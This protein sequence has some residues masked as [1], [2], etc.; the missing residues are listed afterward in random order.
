[1]PGQPKT[2]QMVERLKS[3]GGLDWLC[4]HIADGE[5]LRDIAAEHLGCSRFTVVRWL[6]K[7]L[8]RKTRYDEARTES[9]SAM[10]EHSKKLLDDADVSS[11]AS[12]QKARNIADFCKWYAGVLDRPNFG[13]PDQKSL[14]SVSI[15]HL[16]LSALQAHGGPPDTQPLLETRTALCLESGNTSDNGTQESL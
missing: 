13:P 14:V 7:D 5:S 4:E 2:R 8:D 6:K 10:A 16:H 15:E 1:M 11:T 3:L 12:V 9:A